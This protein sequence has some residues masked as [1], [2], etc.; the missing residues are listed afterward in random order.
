MCERRLCLDLHLRGAR[1][2]PV[3]FFNEAREDARRLDADFAETGLL[4]GPLH[5]V[6]ISLK[7][8]CAFR[9]HFPV[10]IPLFSFSL[11]GNTRSS[12]T[13]ANDEECPRSNFSRRERIRQYDRIHAVGE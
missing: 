4:K 11:W 7:D 12:V 8:L 5:G 10:S 6:P 9:P 13:M 3:V 1:A 2:V